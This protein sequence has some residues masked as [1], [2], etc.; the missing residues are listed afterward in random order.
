MVLSPRSLNAT[1]FPS[2]SGKPRMETAG[3]EAAEAK[4]LLRCSRS[5]L[6]QI[7]L[8]AEKADDSMQ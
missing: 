4:G 5:H 1:T 8:T 2:V 3:A 7:G 6:S